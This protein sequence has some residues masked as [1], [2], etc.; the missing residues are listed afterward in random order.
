MGEAIGQD[1]G[2]TLAS[3]RQSGS[4][5]DFRR[6]PRGT[7]RGRSPFLVLT[8]RSAASRDEN[9]ECCSNKSCNTESWFPGSVSELSPGE[10]AVQR[11]KRARLGIYK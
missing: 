3:F 5:G 2:D 11:S 4:P 10:K 8:K 1:E 9:G 6:L 7:P